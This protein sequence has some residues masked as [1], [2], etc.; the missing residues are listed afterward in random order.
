MSSHPT[1]GTINLTDHEDIRNDLH[2]YTIQSVIQNKLAN[3]ILQEIS[4]IINPM[5]NTLP[6]AQRRALP[7]L[8][9]EYCKALKIFQN[10]LD[11]SIPTNC[12]E[13]DGGEP[14]PPRISSNVLHIRRTSVS[15]TSGCGLTWQLSLFLCSRPSTTYLP[16]HPPP[17][18]RTTT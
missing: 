5:E 3:P 1:N 4:L 15:R 11:P 10:L 12:P 18:A 8:R 14:T 17:P 16:F 9:S 13:C 2:H 6:R 7:Q